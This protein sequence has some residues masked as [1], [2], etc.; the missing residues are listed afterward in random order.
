M[1]YFRP[2]QDERRRE[3]E[4]CLEKNREN[5]RLSHIYL[6]VDDDVEVG[7]ILDACDELN[8]RRLGHCCFVGDDLYC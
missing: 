3:L 1:P 8:I 5:G 4:L 7:A 6:M 2:A